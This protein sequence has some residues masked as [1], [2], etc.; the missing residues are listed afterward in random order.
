MGVGKANLEKFKEECDEYLNHINDNMAI[1]NLDK[2]IRQG[3]R[4]AALRSMSKSKGK[5]N[6][7][8]TMVG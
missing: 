5:K 2:E 3:I 4:K 1:E 6:K 8:S 7:G